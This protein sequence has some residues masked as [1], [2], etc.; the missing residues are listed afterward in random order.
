MFYSDGG[1]KYMYLARFDILYE[2]CLRIG[3]NIEGKQRLSVLIPFDIIYAATQE[4]MSK[5]DSG[6]I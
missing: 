5:G 3:F 2:E 6:A 4:N 1:Q